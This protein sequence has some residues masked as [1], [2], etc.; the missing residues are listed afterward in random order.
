M[1]SAPKLSICIPTYNR[2]NTLQETLESILPQVAENPAV[3]VVISDNASTD[4]TANLCRE[5]ESRFPIVRYYPNSEN[6]GFD[7]NVAA[8]VRK[9]QGE[10]I[11]FFSDDDL[12]PPDTFP[13]LLNHLIR[14][15]P[16]ILYINHTPFLHNN[17][18]HRMEPMAPRLEQE[19]TDGKEYFFFAGLGFLSALTV[20]TEYA[21]QF[22]EQVNYGRGTSHLDLVARVAL[23]QEGPFLYVGTL[24]VFARY[25]YKSSGDIL[26]HGLMN[27][28][29]LH[30]ELQQEKLLSAEDIRRLIHSI[31]RH[32]LPRCVLNNRC[33]KTGVV[34]TAELVGL[35]GHDPFFYL[36]VYPL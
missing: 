2:V 4:N 11:S 18:C 21:R 19:F 29:K 5:F 36:Y 20:K 17:P 27:V 16:A 13:A 3:E 30:L 35:Y 9:A 23:T 32:P 34:R 24:M 33:R 15:K 6:L 1:I 14:R 22:I 7:G 25:E 12:S 31:I 26:T 28:T 10:Y 8:C